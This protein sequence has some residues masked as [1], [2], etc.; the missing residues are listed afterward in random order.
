MTLGYI[1]GQVGGMTYSDVMEKTGDHETAMAA[2]KFHVVAEV[3][4]ETW[5]VMAILR[6]SKAGEG[7]IRMLEA[8][9]G[10]GVQE[11]LTEVLQST[12]DMVELENMS[13]KDALRNIDWAQVGYAGMLGFAIGGGL[14]T[15]GA[16][17]DSLAKKPK[18]DAAPDPA[19]PDGKPAGPLER[20][21]DVAAD[22]GAATTEI[23]DDGT[24]LSEEEA[25]PDI[26]PEPD[27]DIAAQ[28]EAVRDPELP[29]DSLFI[30]NG[31]RIP[32]DMNLEGLEVIKG[33][34]GTLIT[35][36]ATK[37][38]DF[39]EDDS[40]DSV[41]SIMGYQQSSGQVGTGIAA[42]ESASTLVVRNDEGNP[43]HQETVSEAEHTDAVVRLDEKY[44]GRVEIHDPIEFQ[45]E[46][47]NR[48]ELEEA[49]RVVLDSEEVADEQPATEPVEEVEPEA[50]PLDW[51]PADEQKPSDEGATSSTV[52]EAEHTDAVVR[53]D[54][55]YPGRVEIHDPIEF[56]KERNNR[57]EL[58]EATRVVLDS[59][60][61]ADEQPATEPVEEVEPEAKPLDW[62]PADEQKPSDEGA[63]AT[64]TEKPEQPQTELPGDEDRDAE[65]TAELKAIDDDYQS[66]VL[67]PRDLA[68]ALEGVE[69]LPAGMRS[70]IDQ[71]M[72]AF[73]R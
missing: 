57:F 58:E 11:M 30:N 38:K 35:S 70:A 5:P 50:K 46:R 17:A 33:R 29:K 13:L 3:I 60:E 54:E 56:Q 14:A 12:Y 62:V 72:R 71:Y 61:V 36:N 48:F 9:I 40:S 52:S 2:S 6:K 41:A 69:N 4:P 55:K 68:E 26:K 18:P 31:T 42:G 53:L 32:E 23:D 67:L 51:V 22:T 44:P 21:A 63:T 49:T 20:A 28:L 47:N 8:T 64:I 1:G 7:M 43:I 19:E 39:E 34:R 16:I 45:K 59:E 73:I 15:P 65:T 66:G 27:S 24:G 37:A 10:E 25:I